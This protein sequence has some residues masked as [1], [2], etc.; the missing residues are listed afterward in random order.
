MPTVFLW[1]G[2]TEPAKLVDFKSKGVAP[3]SV[4]SALFAPDRERTI[5]T[6]VSALTVSALELLGKP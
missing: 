5:R 6:G 4:H 2:A 3:P 1:V